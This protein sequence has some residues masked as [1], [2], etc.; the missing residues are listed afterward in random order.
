MEQTS[1][2]QAQS[3]PSA[4]VSSRVGLGATLVALAGLGQVGYGIMFL[5]RNFTDFIELGLTPEHVGSTPE[6]IQSFSPALYNYISHLHVALSGFMIG[7][8][9]AVIALAWYGIR[10]GERWAL[11]TTLLSVVITAVVSLPLHYVY[12]IGTLGHLGV[13]YLG[14]MTL[15]AGIALAYT[16][17]ATGEH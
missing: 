8:G 16:S 1:S 5:I 15:L 6:Q 9:V 7:L 3:K 17:F 4:S 11:W 2:D 12:G 14:L 13:E 10:R